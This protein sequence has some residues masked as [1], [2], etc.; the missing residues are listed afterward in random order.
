MRSLYKEHCLEVNCRTPTVNTVPPAGLK[1]R[2]KKLV[3]CPEPSWE[4]GLVLNQ[5]VFFVS[6][7]VQEDSRQKTQIYD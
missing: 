5:P 7:E 6:E 1:E 3:A 4:G 2:E